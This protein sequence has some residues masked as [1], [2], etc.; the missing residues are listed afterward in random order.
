MAII[1]KKHHE[2]VPIFS[3]QVI[4]RYEQFSYKG[5]EVDVMTSNKN[6]DGTTKFL[7][8]EKGLTGIASKYEGESNEFSGN[9]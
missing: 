2:L 1:D 7:K 6:E 5:L 8:L 9:L 4:A 3:S